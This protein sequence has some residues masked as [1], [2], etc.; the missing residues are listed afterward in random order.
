MIHRTLTWQ[1]TYLRP[2][3]ISPINDLQKTV[4]HMQKMES[5]TPTFSEPASQSIDYKFLESALGTIIWIM[6]W[7]STFNTG[8]LGRTMVSILTNLE[9]HRCRAH[10]G[11]VGYVVALPHRVLSSSLRSIYFVALG[12][13]IVCASSSGSWCHT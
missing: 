3:W 7:V 10:C 1:L 4:Y 9:L 12:C 5:W 13:D 6:I 2:D 11:H 8:A